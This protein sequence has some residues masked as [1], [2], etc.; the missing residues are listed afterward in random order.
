MNYFLKIFLKNIIKPFIKNQFFIKFY[1]SKYYF[2]KNA[3]K[4]IF[5][6]KKVN[7]GLANA[8]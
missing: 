7:K 3:P 5:S 6:Q 1:K 4:A 2:F 8:K